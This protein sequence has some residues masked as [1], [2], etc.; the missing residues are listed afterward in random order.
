MYRYLY[1]FFL[2]FS[3]SDTQ[4]CTHVFRVLALG[5]GWEISLLLSLPTVCR[6][7]LNLVI[8]VVTHTHIFPAK[9][10]H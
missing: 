2:V 8:V 5:T 9:I 10:T 1:L 3:E 6:L 7:L 4:L